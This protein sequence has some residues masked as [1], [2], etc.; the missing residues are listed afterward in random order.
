MQRNSFLRAVA[1][2]LTPVLEKLCKDPKEYGENA[3]VFARR[4][5]HENIMRR[6]LML[7]IH[8]QRI[9]CRIYLD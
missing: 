2:Y 6:L 5:R 7:E 8:K 9:G 3:F 4:Q 1:I